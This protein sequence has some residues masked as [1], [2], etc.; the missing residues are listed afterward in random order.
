MHGIDFEFVSRLLRYA[1][2]VN[3]LGVAI[4]SINITQSLNASTPWNYVNY[5][6]KHGDKIE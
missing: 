5:H 1:I 3:D 2:I 4:I 6:K